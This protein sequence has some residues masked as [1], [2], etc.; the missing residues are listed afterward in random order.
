MCSNTKK[1]QLVLSNLIVTKNSSDCQSS[2]HLK[3][4]QNTKE[5]N[6]EA[7]IKSLTCSER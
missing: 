2:S 4:S 5:E 6:S 7:L 3:M 1:G